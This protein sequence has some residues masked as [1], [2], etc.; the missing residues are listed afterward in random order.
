M[1]M[2]GMELLLAQKMRLPIVFAVFNDARYNMVFHGSSGMYGEGL[3]WE[4]HPVDFAAWAASMGI[5]G[6]KI[7][8]AHMLEE[9]DWDEATANG[10]C[11][12]DIV[13]DRSV[14]MGGGRNDILKH[15]SSTE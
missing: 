13:I 3:S 8:S 5:W 10:P 15:M 2:N 14:M 6:R 12:L 4:T 7:T 11:V 9:I 1:Q